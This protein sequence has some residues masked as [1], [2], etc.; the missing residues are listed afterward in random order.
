MYINKTF[1]HNKQAEQN[2]ITSRKT[3]TQTHPPPQTSHR[4]HSVFPHG[5][6]RSLPHNRTIPNVQ[7]L[8]FHCISSLREPVDKHLH[9]ILCLY[10]AWLPLH[11]SGE[12]LFN[13]YCNGRYSR[14]PSVIL[15]RS[16]HQVLI[17]V[18]MEGTLGELIL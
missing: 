11:F 8:P 10:S 7:I 12:I 14:S 5:S 16:S 17:L 3:D 9:Y 13:P 15:H 4:I 2:Q 18:L 6:G 1:R